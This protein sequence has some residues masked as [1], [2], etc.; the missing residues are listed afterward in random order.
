MEQKSPFFLYFKN[1]ADVHAGVWKST[2]KAG[3]VFL[4]LTASPLK[5]LAL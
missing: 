4:E 3:T 1:Y 5:R 2:E